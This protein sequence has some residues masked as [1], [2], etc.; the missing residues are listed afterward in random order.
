MQ[1]TPKLKL[2]LLSSFKYKGGQN[3]QEGCQISAKKINREG[4]VTRTL[5]KISK[6]NKQGGWNKWGGWQ[7]HSY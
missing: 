5:A 6:V 3:K 4:K 2:V 1:D 7:K